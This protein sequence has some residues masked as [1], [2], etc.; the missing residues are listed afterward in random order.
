MSRNGPIGYPGTRPPVR[1][2]LADD[3]YTA[4]PT[5]QPQPPHMAAAAV[6]LSRRRSTAI[7]RLTASNRAILSSPCMAQRRPRPA[8]GLQPAAGPRP[9]AQPPGYYF[10]QAAGEQSRHGYAPPTAGHQL[11]FGGSDASAGAELCA[12]SHSMRRRFRGAASSPIRAATISAT[13]CRQRR[14]GYAPAE[15]RS[16]SSKRT[17]RLRCSS[18]ITIRPTSAPATR[19]R[20]D[21]RRLRR[22]VGRG[23][24]GAAARGRRGLMI[25]AALVG[26]IGLGGAH[27][28]HLQDLRCLDWSAGAGDQG[29]GLRAQQGQARGAGRQGLPAHGQEASEPARRG[30]QRACSRGCR[31]PAHGRAQPATIPTGRARSRS[32]HHAGRSARALRR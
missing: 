32:F 28:L 15:A 4:P 30:G 7:S 12:R 9:A 25:A 18:T 5:G 24:G 16:S 8:A 2:P 19:L 1:R 31:G 26:A 6:C 23:G 14:Q 10:P 20:R 27:G 22:D 29:R 17:I 3:P 21:R 11:P 13:T